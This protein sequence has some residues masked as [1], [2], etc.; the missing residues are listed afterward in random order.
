MVVCCGRGAT[1]RGGSGGADSAAR[2]CNVEARECGWGQRRAGEVEPIANSQLGLCGG[3]SRPATCWGMHVPVSSRP[4]LMDSELQCHR[5]GSRVWR[6][7][8]DRSAAMGWP[9]CGV[10]KTDAPTRLEPN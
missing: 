1:F 10:L 8:C 6:D 7:G 3:N 5:T 9:C 2:C 4:P